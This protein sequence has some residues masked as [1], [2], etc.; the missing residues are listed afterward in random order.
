VQFSKG[1]AWNPDLAPQQQNGFK[2]HSENLQQLRAQK[3]ISFG[4]RYD[5]FGM[6]FLHATSLQSARSL[7]QNDPGVKAGIFQFTVS[8]LNVFYPWQPVS[9]EP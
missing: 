4:A 2:Q 3:R 1:T 7:I 5:D 6:I 8:K 9:P